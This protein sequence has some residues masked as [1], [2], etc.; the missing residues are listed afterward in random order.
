[1][2]PFAAELLRVMRESRDEMMDLLAAKDEQAHPDARVYSREE[3]AQMVHGFVALMTEALEERGGETRAMFN[4]TVMPVLRDQGTPLRMMVQGTM[5]S[6]TMMAAALSPRIE[7][8]LRDDAIVWLADFTS[9][10]VGEIVEIW[11]AKP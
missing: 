7:P 9:D 1:M 8:G 10:Y 3:I 5:R 6:L 2:R 11:L 4:E